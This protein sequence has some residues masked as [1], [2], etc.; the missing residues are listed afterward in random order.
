[1]FFMEVK[2]GSLSWEQLNRYPREG[3]ARH[4]EGQGQRLSD[5]DMV[6]EEERESHFGQSRVSQKRIIEGK[7]EQ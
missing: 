6:L 4:K 5:R 1:M 2:E 3:Y 7:S